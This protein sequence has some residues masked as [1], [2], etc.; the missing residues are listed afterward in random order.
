MSLLHVEESR[1]DMAQGRIVDFGRLAVGELRAHSIT[2]SHYTMMQSHH[3]ESLAR[4]LESTFG[5]EAPL[6]GRLPEITTGAGQGR[7]KLELM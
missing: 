1:N 3:V 2:G 5:R 7:Q 4:Q 6:T